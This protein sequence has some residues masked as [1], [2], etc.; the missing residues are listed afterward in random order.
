MYNEKLN[1]YL[2]EAVRDG[3]SKKV[4]YLL[5]IGASVLALKDGKTIL[6]EAKEVNQEE[7]VSSIEQE[8]VKE[9]EKT[10]KNDKVNEVIKV[11]NR[12][13]GG[14]ILVSEV[15][16]LELGQKLVVAVDKGNIIESYKL[17]NKGADVNFLSLYGNNPLILACD[18][19]NGFHTMKTLIF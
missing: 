12:I 10:I 7:I 5:E 9:F 3:N 19:G 14:E 17:I 6:E 2:F 15:N 8:L 4:K 13:N 18:K 1:D 11:L 16:A